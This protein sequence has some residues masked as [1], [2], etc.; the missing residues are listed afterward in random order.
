MAFADALLL[1]GLWLAYFILHSL[2]ASLWLKRLVAKRWPGFMPAY[3]LL[4]NALALLLL[5]PPVALMYRL[6]GEFLWQWNGVGAWLVNGLALLAVLGLFWSLRYYDGKEFLGLRQWQNGSRSVEDQEI[7]RISPLHRYVRHPWYALALV[8]I[9][10]RDMDPALL[11]SAVPISLYFI[12]G[13]RLEEAKLMSYHG[14]AYGRY[15]K[16]VPALFP[17]PWRHLSKAEAEMLMQEAAV[18]LRQD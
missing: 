6:K 2:T 8:M 10:T 12:I 3:R 16:W 13:S 4:F 1:T 14:E 11:C 17:L 15:R 9:W 18:N 7:F 5:L